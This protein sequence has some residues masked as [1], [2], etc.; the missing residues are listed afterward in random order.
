[1]TEVS[2]RVRGLFPD[3]HKLNGEIGKIASK[4]SGLLELIYFVARE[5][6]A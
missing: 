1:M 2:P 6:L 3:F 5:V 4:K